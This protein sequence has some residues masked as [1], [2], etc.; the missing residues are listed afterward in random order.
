MK[1]NLKKLAIFFIISYNNA[2]PFQNINFGMLTMFHLKSYRQRF[3]QNALTPITFS[4]TSNYI[5][6]H[7]L[8]KLQK[9]DSFSIHFIF[10]GIKTMASKR[11]PCLQ[12]NI[13]SRSRTFYYL[14]PE[15]RMK[16]TNFI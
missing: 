13:L 14:F 11:T 3:S 15:N 16:L 1:T 12:I 8:H 10:Y 9:F 2:E 7:K 5:N 6:L 4:I